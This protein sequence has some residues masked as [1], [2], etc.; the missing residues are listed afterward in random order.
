MID[1]LEQQVLELENKQDAI[2]EK[3]YQEHEKQD[4]LTAEKKVSR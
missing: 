3:I 4:I 1:Q 2:Q